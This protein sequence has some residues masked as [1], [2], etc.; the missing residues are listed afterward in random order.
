M[1]A[2]LEMKKRI[3]A[4]VALLA[5]VGLS[6]SSAVREFVLFCLVLGLMYLSV[7]TFS[8]SAQPWYP[9]SFPEDVPFALKYRAAHAYLAEYDVRFALRSG[10]EI[11]SY[12]DAGGMGDFAFYRLPDG[13][14][15][16]MTA[17]LHRQGRSDYLVDDANGAVAVKYRD[18]SWHPKPD[19][20]TTVDP[21][22]DDLMERRTFLGCAHP[23]GR[24]VADCPDPYGPHE[25]D[26]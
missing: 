17:Y 19:D 9:V 2:V 14:Y 20:G 7:L 23:D 13:R 4:G 5:V 21:P 6:F 15:Y 16:V 12:V 18:G 3:I 24:F 26:E 22:P 8:P 25:P 10:R 11:T 1:V